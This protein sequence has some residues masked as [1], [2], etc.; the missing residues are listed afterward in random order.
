M[1]NITS[2]AIRGL[3]FEI[4]LQDLNPC[5]ASEITG[6]YQITNTTTKPVIFYTFS[7]AVPPALKNL[8]P[9][10]VNALLSGTHVLFDSDPGLAASAFNPVV[11]GVESNGIYN[12][13]EEDG[14]RK[15]VPAALFST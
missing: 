12:F 5:E 2:Q 4:L 13:V 6:G 7:P 10:G 1:K 14:V 15:L 3:E 9:G 11:E 8:A